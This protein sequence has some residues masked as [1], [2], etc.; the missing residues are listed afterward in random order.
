MLER[1]K[2]EASF[3]S[4]Y[5]DTAEEADLVRD[6]AEPELAELQDPV[7][8]YCAVQEAEFF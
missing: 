8:F 1:L 4:A 3:W 7:L 2:G 5:L 6:W